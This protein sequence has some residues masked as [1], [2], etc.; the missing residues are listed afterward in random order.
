MEKRVEIK[1]GRK[2]G[3]HEYNRIWNWCIMGSFEFYHQPGTFISPKGSKWRP[4]GL[5]YPGVLLINQDN[6]IR[7]SIDHGTI[8][9][10][11]RFGWRFVPDKKS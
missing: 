11:S 6:N 3:Y 4:Y 5:Y 1:R 9:R 2:V 7:H 10:M 8:L